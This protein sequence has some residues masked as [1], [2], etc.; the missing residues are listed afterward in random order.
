MA[1]GRGCASGDVRQ[2]SD[3]DSG[4]VVGLWRDCPRISG[5]GVRVVR[6]RCIRTWRTLSADLDRPRLGVVANESESDG[7]KLACRHCQRVAAPSISRGFDI[8][9]RGRTL[10]TSRDQGP[11]ERIPSQTKP[12]G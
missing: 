7:V 9:I 1:G 10:S 8:A 4:R 5:L 12:L 11:T 6:D 3:S 2:C